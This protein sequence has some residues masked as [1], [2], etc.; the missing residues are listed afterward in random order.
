MKQILFELLEFQ[1]VPSETLSLPP[2]NSTCGGQVGNCLFLSLNVHLL[3]C[4]SFCIKI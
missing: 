1:I 2:A 3:F 4:D